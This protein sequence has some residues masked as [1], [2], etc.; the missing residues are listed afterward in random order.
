MAD[1]GYKKIEESFL[2]ARNYANDLA[3]LLSVAGKNTKAANA[4]R[5]QAYPDD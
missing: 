1:E 5:R 3:D 4:R 2:G